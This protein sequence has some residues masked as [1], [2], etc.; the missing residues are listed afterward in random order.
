[1]CLMHTVFSLASLLFI[2]FCLLPSAAMAPPEDFEK[3]RLEDLAV[4]SVG[5]R[6]RRGSTFPLGQTK[7]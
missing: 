7:S 6:L 5:R 4:P 1:M 2:Y 3:A